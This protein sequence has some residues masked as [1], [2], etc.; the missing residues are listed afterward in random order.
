M[1]KARARS[2]DPSTDHDL[3]VRDFSAAGDGKTLDTAAFQ[4]AMDACCQAGGGTVRVP[5]GVYV[6]GTIELR[7]NV[8]LYL[9]AGAVVRGSGDREHYPHQTLIYA[10]GAVNAA[11]R[12]RG[13]I[14]GNGTAF[15]KR[16]DGLWVL[17]DWRPEVLL[18]LLRCE[19]LLIEDIIIRNSPG[20]TIRPVG[21]NRLMIRGISILNGLSDDEHG[22]NTDGIDPDCCTNVRISDCHIQSGD[23]CIVVKITD[24]FDVPRV[25]HD[26]TVTNCV[27]TTKQTALTIGSESYGEFRNITF[28]NCVVHNASCG[29]G[30]WMSDGGLIDGWL[31]NNI[32]ITLTRGGT[33]IYMWSWRREDTT[34][35]G[36]V[37]NVMISNVTATGDSCMF[38]SGVKERPIESVTLDNIRLFLR[39]RGERPNHADPPYPF[40]RWGMIR[41][42]Y[43]MFCR[44]VDDLKLRNVKVTR[45]CP[46]RPQWGSALRCVG[47]SNLDI[48]ALDGRQ[49]LGS[50]APA[51]SLAAVRGAMIRNCRA[52][53]GTGTF[54][55]IGA[56]SEAIS[57][58]GND[59]C[60]AERIVDVDPD[61][62]AGEFFQ[63]ANRPPA[64]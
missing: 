10:D 49:A 35:W 8:T 5:P 46:E 37:R 3:N 60:R 44:Y 17:G 53:E 9:Q 48:D 19:G 21:C 20:W 43:D 28:S 25:S 14:D 34:P 12:G 64:G 36:Q 27:L 24:D 45:A 6:V 61:A 52:P 32:A 42:P 26:I 55:R 11:I 1:S 33:P 4:G 31:V 22:P 54:L 2:D 39:G 30:L 59:L 7:D 51:I 63:A 62:D 23:D 50:D 58:I 56:G 29:V 13:I 57:L 47:V 18:L 41:A 40:V 15:W 16:Q 38:I